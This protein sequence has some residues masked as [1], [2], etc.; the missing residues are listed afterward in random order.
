[1]VIL[2]GVVLSAGWQTPCESIVGRLTLLLDMEEMN[3]YLCCRKRRQ[4]QLGVLRN[5]FA[6]FEAN[7][8][9]VWLEET[10]IASESVRT[11]FATLR[12]VRWNWALNYID[13]ALVSVAI[14]ATHGKAGLQAVAG[15]AEPA[16]AQARAPMLSPPPGRFCTMT[17]CPSSLE[18]LSA[19][20][21][22]TRSVAE[23][24]DWG[25][26]I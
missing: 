1:M 22:P 15:G 17:D 25:E 19:Y 14:A 10:A 20:I 4:K 18:S 23:P 9:A 2:P 6:T 12:D 26:R 7:M 8:A 13:I 24:G 16:S 3:L 11:Y 21:L 5:D